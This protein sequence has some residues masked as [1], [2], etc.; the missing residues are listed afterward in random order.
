MASA[1]L[2][3]FL[4]CCCCLFVLVHAMDDGAAAAA[5]MQSGELLALFEVMGALLQDPGWAQLHPRPCTDTPWPGVQ[6]EM[7]LEPPVLQQ[8]DPHLHVTELHIGPDVASPPCKH[9]ASL[10]PALLQLPYLKSLSLFG[11]F[12]A[13]DT[14]PLPP[15]LF[16]NAS[17]LEQ[18]VIKSNPGLS[19]TIPPS[20]GALHGLR[21]LCLSQNSL[22]GAIPKELGSLARLEQLDLSYNN[23]SGSI[24]VELGGGLS[25]LTI[26]DLSWNGLQGEIPPSIGDLW[27]LQKL[28]LSYNKISGRIPAVVGRLE[29]LVLL[30]LSHNSLAGPVPDEL[31]GLSRVQY[32]LVESNPIGTTI[33]SFL[34]TIKSLVVLGLSDCGLSGHVPTFLGV[35]SNLTSLSLDRNKLDGTIPSTTLEA[36]PNLDQLNLSQN[37]LSGVLS[38][39][40]EFVSRLGRRLDVRDNQG[41]C[42]NPASHQINTLLPFYLQAPPCPTTASSSSNGTPETGEMMKSNSD[43]MRLNYGPLIGSCLVVLVAVVHFLNFF[44]FSSLLEIVLCLSFSGIMR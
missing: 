30:D 6:C 11:C 2:A 17:A 29:R 26:F 23:L 9:S 18:L 5:G 3:K 42:M 4:A 1:C 8:Q 10:S 36:I 21:V 28:D 20:L 22:H 34:K 12:L 14:V 37:L 31:S 13:E 43:G 41:L 27:R 24:P 32:F 25:S 19:G 39:S 15:S 38:F 44:F 16:T 35:L 7:V 40:E 33:P